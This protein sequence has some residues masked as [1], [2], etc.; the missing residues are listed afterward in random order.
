MD[1]NLNGKLFR[2]VSNSENGD[3][4]S[5]TLFYYHQRGEVVTARYVGG[6]IVEG[7]LI[8]KMLPDGQLD[9][10]YHHLNTTGEFM[11]GRCLSTPTLLTDGRLKFSEEWQWLSGDGSSGRSE[12]EEVREG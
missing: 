10:R 1:Y 5:A 8:A 12:I 2:S 11:L 6:S 3:V 9:M 7:H 4:D